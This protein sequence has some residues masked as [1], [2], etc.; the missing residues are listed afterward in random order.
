MMRAAG[1]GPDGVRLRGIIVVL[2]RAGLRISEALAL[3]GTDLEPARGPRWSGTA[4]AISDVRSGWTAQPSRTS[5][6]G[7]SSA[8]TRQWAA[9]SSREP[10][11]GVL[12]A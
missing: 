8:G 12:R 2:W 1:E 7:L 6:R 10:G 4:R 3:N 9:C 5:S 11:G